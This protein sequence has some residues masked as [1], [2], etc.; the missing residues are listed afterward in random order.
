MPIAMLTTPSQPDIDLALAHH[1]AGRLDE[2]ARLYERILAAAPAHGDALNFLGLVA[3]QRGDLARSRML[4]TQATDALPRSPDARYQL[5]LVLAAQGDGTAALE[6]HGRAAALAPGRA[7]ILCEIGRLQAQAGRLGEAAATYRG[8]VAADPTCIPAAENLATLLDAAGDRKAA[9]GVLRAAS[10]AAYQRKDLAAAKRTAKAALALLPMQHVS[11]VAGAPRLAL[12]SGVE[13]TFVAWRSDTDLMFGGSHLNTA[14]LL[15]AGAFSID[16]A[17]LGQAH[18]RETLAR[19]PRP[20]LVLTTIADPDIEPNALRAAEAYVTAL[21][22]P[23]VN[24]PG[25]VWNTTR[26]AVSRIVAGIDGLVMGRTVKVACDRPETF[27]IA[28]FAAANGFAFPILIRPAGTQTGEGLIRVDGPDEARGKSLDRRYRE[29]YVIQYIEYQSA[30]G[31]HRKTRLISVDGAIFP[32][33]HVMA[34]HWNSRLSNARPVMHQHPHLLAEEVDVLDRCEDL[35]GPHR[36]SALR[37]LHRR[38]GLDYFGIDCNVLPDG[39]LLIFE[40]N[41]CMRRQIHEVRQ[42]ADYLVP[43][44]KRV[45]AAFQALLARKLATGGTPSGRGAAMA[46]DRTDIL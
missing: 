41:A 45:T 34:P 42:G 31:Y 27:D 12:L 16:V 14:G 19:L 37:T 43:H 9:S 18:D 39:R 46:P 17:F 44:L 5:G 11:T 26:D 20:D 29:M 1:R 23:V 21:G 24:D 28:A 30:D 2:A 10:V 35:L 4:L 25:Q 22:T 15:D 13:N 6:Q 7:D 3:W 32:D 36:L 40:A 33:H 8:I 38:L